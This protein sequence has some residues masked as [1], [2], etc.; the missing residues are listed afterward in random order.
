[1]ITGTVTDGLTNAP[2]AGAQVSTQPATA[3]A[4]TDSSGHYTLDVPF[5]AYNVV[6][7]AAGYNSDFAPTA[8]SLGATVTLNQALVAVP[9]LA[10]QDLFSR[11]DQ[12][13]IGTASDG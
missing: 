6:T 12:P 7:S 5:G 13:G 9:P 11:A 8:T 3:T 2:L 10:A 1:T 4:A